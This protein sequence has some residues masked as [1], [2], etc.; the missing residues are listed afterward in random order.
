MFII[1]MSKFIFNMFLSFA[2][3]NIFNCKIYVK[4]NI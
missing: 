4:E 2:N 3:V 1:N